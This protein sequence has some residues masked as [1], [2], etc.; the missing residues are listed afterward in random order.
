MKEPFKREGP[1]RRRAP[2]SPWPQLADF[3][4]AW[5]VEN[6]DAPCGRFTEDLTPIIGFRLTAT[7]HEAQL[8]HD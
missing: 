4:R 8:R 3:F 1:H 6:F 5:P 7:P 2:N